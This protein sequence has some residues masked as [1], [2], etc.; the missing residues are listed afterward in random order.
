MQRPC[1][2]RCCAEFEEIKESNSA[3]VGTSVAGDGGRQGPDQWG[4]HGHVTDSLVF[5]Q[6]ESIWKF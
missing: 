4:L 2:R 1:G 3:G 5:I 6:M